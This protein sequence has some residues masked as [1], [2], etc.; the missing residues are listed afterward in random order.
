MNIHSGAQ[1]FRNEIIS[2]FYSNNLKSSDPFSSFG[3][4]IFCFKQQLF[5]EHIIY[6]FNINNDHI[7][8]FVISHEHFSSNEIPVH[9]LAN[10]DSTFYLLTNKNLNSV[11][12]STSSREAKVNKVN[13][14]IT[15]KDHFFKVFLNKQ[16]Q[17]VLASYFCADPKKEP[18]LV[19]YNLATQNRKEEFVICDLFNFQSSSYSLVDYR[20]GLW[21]VVK[22]NFDN[23]I[24]LLDDDFKQIKRI[25]LLGEK[26]V[27]LEQ[28]KN[29]AE[30]HR[31]YNLLGSQKLFDELGNISDTI[32]TISKVLF[33]TDTTLL[34]VGFN[35]T[36]NTID[37]FHRIYQLNVD[38]SLTL[39]QSLPYT[40][41]KEKMQLPFTKKDL[42]Y[43][44]YGK[45]ISSYKNGIISFERLPDFD[46]IKL[47]R[48][49]GNT[50]VRTE[51]EGLVV[52]RI[53]LRSTIPIHRE[54]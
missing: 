13:T 27:P 43:N 11:L 33:I 24:Y 38:Y 3:D 30:M 19:L 52:Y 48:D 25:N 40:Y 7:D 2:E 42:P 14:G 47:N 50:I 51:R 45:T 22:D 17:L 32:P 4:H 28:Q 8:S 15:E 29:I 16:N 49:Y 9:C 36:N 1:T 53:E 18:K 21:L 39:L 41:P 35:D 12:L 20:N 10:T 46:S 26:I 34:I 37:G 54:E 31:R 44:W 6:R 23:C 5:I